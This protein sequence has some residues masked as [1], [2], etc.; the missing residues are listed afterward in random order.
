[1]LRYKYTAEVP[2]YLGGEFNEI[3]LV[4]RLDLCIGCSNAMAV[5][6]HSKKAEA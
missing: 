4:I 3:S 1:M 2:R 5:P 6:W